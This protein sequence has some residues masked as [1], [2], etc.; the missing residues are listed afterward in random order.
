MRRAIFTKAGQSRRAHTESMLGRQLEQP[1]DKLPFRRRARGF[2]CRQLA[3]GFTR[4]S[5]VVSCL[6]HAFQPKLRRPAIKILPSRSSN[7]RITSN[8]SL[9]ERGCLG[10]SLSALSRAARSALSGFGER[11]ELPFRRNSCGFSTAAQRTRKAGSH[12][13]I[14]SNSFSQPG[15]RC[16][17]VTVGGSESLHPLLVPGRPSLP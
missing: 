12:T 2:R 5:P 10:S 15:R 8:L 6:A 11:L 1:V 16:A 4:Q 13:P 3:L 14:Q 7:F 9:T 17:H